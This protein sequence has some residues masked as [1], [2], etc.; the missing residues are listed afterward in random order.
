MAKRI[1][2]PWPKTTARD[3]PVRVKRTGPRLTAREKFIAKQALRTP[4]QA[5]FRRMSTQ[6]GDDRAIAFHR[7]MAASQDADFAFMFGIK[8]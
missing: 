4:E 8:P 1:N 6:A 2:L 7:R 5:A 3:K